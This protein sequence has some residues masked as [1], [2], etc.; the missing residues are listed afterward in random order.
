MIKDEIKN[1]KESDKDLRKFGLTIGIIIIL[2]AALLFWKQKPSFIYFFPVGLF[3]VLAGIFTPPLLRPLNKGWMIFSVL[4]GWV[5]TRVIL[6]VLYYI[7]LTPIGIIAKISGKK[8]LE[9]K[10]DKSK[11]SYWEKRVKTEL[12]TADYERQF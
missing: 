4:L 10:I 12:N 6:S 3:L 7:I 2:I 1:I 9:L 8:F 5:M 11:E